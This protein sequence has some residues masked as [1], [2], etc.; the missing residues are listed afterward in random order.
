[1]HFH[2]DILEMGYIQLT[3][4]IA[5]NAMEI[6]VRQLQTHSHELSHVPHVPVLEIE[7]K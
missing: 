4:A 5:L 6:Q 2:P 7:I 1:V 3:I